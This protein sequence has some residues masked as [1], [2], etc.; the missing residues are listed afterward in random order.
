MFANV[1]F[2]FIK[3]LNMFNIKKSVEKNEHNKSNK[4]KYCCDYWSY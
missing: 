2:F 3:F 1:V 4:K